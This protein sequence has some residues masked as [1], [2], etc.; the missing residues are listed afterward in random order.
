HCTTALFVDDSK[1]FKSINTTHDCELLQ[2][3]LNATVKPRCV[4]HPS[5]E[6]LPVSKFFRSPDDSPILYH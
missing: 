4:E 5:L 1:C 2:R 6:C 3:E